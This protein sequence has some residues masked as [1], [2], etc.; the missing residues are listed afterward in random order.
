MRGL[1]VVIDCLARLIRQLEFYR[2]PGFLLPHGG[3]VDR[4][5]V[6]CNVFD[7]E[8]NDIAASQLAIDGQIE[9][10][11]VTDP[12]LDQQSGSDRPNVLWSERRFSPKTLAFV[13]RH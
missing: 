1:Q 12:S 4:I 5:A 13:P 11:K 6:R 2:A 7:L 3:T 9:H 8:G 10:G